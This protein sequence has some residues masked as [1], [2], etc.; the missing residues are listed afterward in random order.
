MIT[1]LSGGTG[2]LALISGVRQILH[3][4]DI[5][6]VASTAGDSWVSGATLRRISMPPSSSSRAPLIPAGGGDQGRYLR[7]P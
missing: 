7:H 5:A 3:D 4:S 6:V 2:T 1:F